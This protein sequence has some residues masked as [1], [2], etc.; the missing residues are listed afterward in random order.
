MAHDKNGVDADAEKRASTSDDQE[1][2][3]NLARAIGGDNES[4]EKKG[5][6]DAIQLRP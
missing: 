2:T 5:Q 1:I 4:K 3:E 6:K